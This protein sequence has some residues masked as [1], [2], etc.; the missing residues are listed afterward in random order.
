[1]TRW[2]GRSELRALKWLGVRTE[3]TSF[4]DPD[5]I[6]VSVAWLPGDMMTSVAAADKN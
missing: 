5:G 4:V 3:G 1:M 6:C 2:I